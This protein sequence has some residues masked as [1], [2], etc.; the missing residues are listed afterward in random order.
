MHVVCV[1]VCVYVRLSDSLHHISTRCHCLFIST[2]FNEQT[3]YRGRLATREVK[4]VRRESF[5]R[6]SSNF[7][8]SR[9]GGGG[10]VETTTTTPGGGERG[11]IAEGDESESSQQDV[12]QSG[13]R[14]ATQSGQRDVAEREG[15]DGADAMDET[16]TE[17]VAALRIQ[18]SFRGF[19]A[20]KRCVF[21][22]RF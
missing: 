8:S 1:C 5:R 15:I 9:I 10:A 20:R 7:V 17:S 16:E 21:G 18:T 12:T 3:A 6:S 11:V 22:P 13:Q 19:R 14:D 2:F 4:R